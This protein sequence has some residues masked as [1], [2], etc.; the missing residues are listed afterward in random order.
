M[1]LGVALFCVALPAL[2]IGIVAIAQNGSMGAV[3]AYPGVTPAPMPPS[4]G[5][6]VPAPAPP[7]VPAPAP[8]EEHNQDPHYEYEGELGPANWG[9]ISPE[10]SMCRAGTYQSP[11][12]LVEAETTAA[13]AGS[14]ITP[15]TMGHFQDVGAYV[16]DNDFRNKAF[17]SFNGHAVTTSSSLASYFTHK[18]RW[19]QLLQFHFHTPSEHTL[20]GVASAA[21]LH[22]VHRTLT[23]SL[24]VIGIMIDEGDSSPLFIQS[25]FSALPTI[26]EGPVEFELSIT[27]L[28]TDIGVPDVPTSFYTYSGS[29]TTP[30]CSENVLWILLKKKVTMRTADI[31]ALSAIM[32]N[33]AR[34]VQPRNG[35]TVF[36]AE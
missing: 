32:G 18:T 36:S 33:T 6:E 10:W 11:I 28:L 3:I 31:A 34:P 14:D 7:A 4:P 2:I 23:G 5:T 21:E 13:P 22:M 8:T 12:D 16:P 30:P 27:Q 29:L 26:A 25:F 9:N 20:G 35:R 1:F 24:A 17:V 19:Y 15:L